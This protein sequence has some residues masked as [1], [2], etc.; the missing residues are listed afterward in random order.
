MNTGKCVDLEGK[1][2]F[3]VSPRI[4]RMGGG[5]LNLCSEVLY[6]KYHA[7][8]RASLCISPPCDAAYF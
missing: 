8:L 5:L 4:R 7:S 3:G 2:L 1:C 6:L